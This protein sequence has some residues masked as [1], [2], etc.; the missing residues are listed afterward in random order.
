MIPNHE[1]R[2]AAFSVNGRGFLLREDKWAYIQ[3]AENAAKG[4]ELFDMETDPQQ[5]T[6]L[7]NSPEHQASGRT[8]QAKTR[9]QTQSGPHQRPERTA[10]ITS[11]LFSRVAAAAYSCGRQPA[12]GVRENL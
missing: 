12:D 11:E 9:R 1:V 6:N 5:Y 10:K 4:I 7:A 3:Y 8:L 2:D